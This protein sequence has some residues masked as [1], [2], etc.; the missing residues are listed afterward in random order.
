M[1]GSCERGNEHLDYTKHKEFLDPLSGTT[2][3]RGPRTPYF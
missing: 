2:A 1:T 3:E